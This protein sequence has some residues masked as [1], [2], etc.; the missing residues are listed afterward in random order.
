MAVK[1]TYAQKIN[2]SKRKELLEKIEDA[3]SFHEK[4]K[5]A[6]FFEPPSSASS[7]RSYEKH[8]QRDIKF[9][10]DGKEYRYGGCARCSCKNVYYSGFFTVDNEIKNV[11]SFKKIR[12]ELISAIEI[13]DRKHN[14]E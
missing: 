3:I 12:D 4:F 11:R 14:A 9:I 13:Y 1:K 7:R 5:N 8:N 6:Y 10:Y 2:Q